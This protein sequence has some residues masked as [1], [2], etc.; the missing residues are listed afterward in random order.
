MLIAW[1]YIK[2]H[3]INNRETLATSRGAL[4]RVLVYFWLFTSIIDL[5]SMDVFPKHLDIFM[6]K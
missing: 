4:Q 6:F 3:F 1:I 2:W 5:E